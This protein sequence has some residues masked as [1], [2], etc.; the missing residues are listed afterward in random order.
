[1][2]ATS[3]SARFGLQCDE[4]GLAHNGLTIYESSVQRSRVY[5]GRTEGFARIRSEQGGRRGFLVK[6]RLRRYLR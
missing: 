1:M 5:R 6:P 3:H 2:C 4:G